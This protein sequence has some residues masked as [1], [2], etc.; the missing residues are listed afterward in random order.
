MRRAL[1]SVVLALAASNGRAAAQTVVFGIGGQLVGEAGAVI[2]IPAYA[3]MRGAPGQMLGSYTVRLQWTPGVLSFVGV[4][5]GAFGQPLVVTDSTY[6]GVLRVGG[7]SASGVDGLFTLFSV[8]MSVTSNQTSAVTLTVSEAV[9]AGTFTD[10]TP[11]VTVVNGTYCPAVGRWG[12]LDGDGQANSRDALAMLS[13]IVGLPLDSSFTVALGDVDADGLVNS[14]DALITLSYTVGLAIPGQRVLVYAPGACGGPGTVGI[15]IL[16]DTVDVAIGQQVRLLL[17]GAV[18]EAP[19]GTSVNWSVG[20]PE[21]AVV[22]PEGVLAGRAAGNTTVTAALGPGLT[23]S[24]PVIVRAQ[25]GTWYVDAARA[26]LAAIQLG[27]QRYPFATPQYAFPIAQDG[28]TVRVAPGV[29]DYLGGDFC[30]GGYYGGDTPPADGPPALAPPPEA[31]ARYGDVGR[32]IVLWGD[33]LTDGTRPVL[34]GNPDADQAVQLFGGISLEMHHLVLRGFYQAIYQSDPTRKLLIENVLFDLTG[35]NTSSG[36]SGYYGVD[37]LILRN[38]RFLGDSAQYAIAVDMNDGLDLAVMDRVVVDDVQYGVYLY[39]VDSLDVRDSQFRPSQYEAI[40]TTGSA[41][42]SHVYVARSEFLGTYDPPLGL[43]DVHSVV[44]EHN[45][46]RTSG[47]Y[48][49]VT[50]TGV[51]YPPR[52]GSRF[53]SRADSLIA[54]PALGTYDYGFLVS[55]LDSIRVDSAVVVGPDSGFV[56]YPGYLYGG[57]EARIMNSTLLNVSGWPLYLGG[58]QLEVA[59]S[60][61]TGCRVSCSTTYGVQGA[62]YADSVSVFQVSGSS[63]YRTYIAVEAPFSGEVHRAELAGNTVDSVYIGFR[64]YTDSSLVTDNMMTRAGAGGGYGMYV[65]ARSQRPSTTAIVERNRISTVAGYALYGNNARLASMGNWYA[66]TAQGIYVYDPSGTAWQVALDRDTVSADSAQGGYAVYLY[67]DLAASVRRSRI[68]GG[69]SG[70]YANVTGGTLA[71]DSNVITGTRSYGVYANAPAGA[72][73]TGQWNNVTDNATYGVYAAGAGAFAFTNGRFVLNRNW[74]VYAASSS[75]DATNNWWG[76]P[77]GPGGGLSD[78]VSGAVTTSP[79]LLFDPASV[80]VPPLAPP[81]GSLVA[82]LWRAPIGSRRAVAATA[83]PQPSVEVPVESQ[84]DVTAWRL[85]RRADA[86]NRR[87]ELLSLR[88]QRRA[89]RAQEVGRR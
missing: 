74:A 87:R 41:A 8:R 55:D 42:G 1:V 48:G 63:F 56:L 22:T 38:V 29:H 75:V 73:V 33:T 7:L 14:R 67:G 51:T 26:Q 20:D 45:V 65:A 30:T 77:F 17:A 34:R 57:A 52:P 11:S 50:A 76:D 2:Q 62:G 68:L 18:G 16:P 5:P 89:A 24:V 44:S 13:A 64:L 54:T 37:T 21:L 78:S 43:Y 32:S 4:E 39:G 60:S 19:V 46:F 35:P 69:G 25:R 15:T 80:S 10:L 6:A 66:G 27:T 86:E 61:F 71:L 9:A 3:D 36:I 31:C 40:Y 79:F 53:V 58:R 49:A 59:N 84:I 47:Y 70:V 82:D 85:A 28:D 72:S 81:A 83:S 88:E 12:D 23:A